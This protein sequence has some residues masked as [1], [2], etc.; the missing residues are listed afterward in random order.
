MGFTVVLL[1]RANFFPSGRLCLH[2]RDAQSVTRTEGGLA[3]AKQTELTCS[4]L[5]RAK[6]IMQAVEQQVSVWRGK[7]RV[8]EGQ[9]GVSPGTRR[10]G[11]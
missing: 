1:G 2:T 11:G 8:V 5:E 3:R 7:G 6:K 10:W 9:A 4:L